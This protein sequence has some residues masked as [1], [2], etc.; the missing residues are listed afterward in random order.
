MIPGKKYTPE[1]ILAI[2]WRRR[3]LIGLPLVLMPLAATM[4]AFTLQTEWMSTALIQIV[5]QRVPRVFVRSTVTARIEDRLESIRQLIL[6]RTRLEA[7][8]QE[9]NLYPE[10]RRQPA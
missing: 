7:L 8:I 2:G 9:F 1:D 10:Q 4:Y 5:P 6:S 3:W